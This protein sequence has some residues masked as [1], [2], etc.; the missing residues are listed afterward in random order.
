MLVVIVIDHILKC[1]FSLGYVTVLVHQFH[2]SHSLQANRWFNFDQILCLE[3]GNVR[4]LIFSPLGL[5]RS[6]SNLWPVRMT[7]ENKLLIEWFLEKGHFVSTKQK[8]NKCLCLVFFGQ[9]YVFMEK[10]AY[11]PAVF[12]CSLTWWQCFMKSC[13]NANSYVKLLRCYLKG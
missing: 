1:R 11:F 3:L 12:L 9:Y 13:F 10:Q 7:D 2:S 6:I 8:L 4:I 5:Y